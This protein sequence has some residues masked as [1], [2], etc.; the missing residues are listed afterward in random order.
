M[1]RIYFWKLVL[2]VF[3][4]INLIDMLIFRIIYDGCC[5]NCVYIWIFWFLMFCYVMLRICFLIL[6]C[7]FFVKY[8]IN[9]VG[10]IVDKNNL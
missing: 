8:I 9:V 3:V 5:F 10:K 2:E 6:F 4:I 1:F 7:V